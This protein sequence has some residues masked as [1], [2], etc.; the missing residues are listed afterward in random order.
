MGDKGF[1]I[2]VMQT[3]GLKL[4]LPPFSRSK[5]QMPAGDVLVTKHCKAQ[6]ACRKGHR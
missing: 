5:R 6:G 4:N 2:E 1:L 3:L